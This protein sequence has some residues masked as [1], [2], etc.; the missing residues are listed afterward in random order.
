MT[1]Q[2]PTRPFGRSGQKVSAIGFGAMG[3]CRRVG[4]IVTTGGSLSVHVR[5]DGYIT[6]RAGMS[7]RLCRVTTSASADATGTSTKRML[8]NTD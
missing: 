8:I 7:A 6:G 3:K 1:S 5:R 4:T 2:L